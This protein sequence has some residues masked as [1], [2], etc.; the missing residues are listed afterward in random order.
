M[1]PL[2]YKKVSLTPL[3]VALSIKSKGF[4]MRP[5]LKGQGFQVS[6]HS[7]PKSPT[8]NEDAVL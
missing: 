1:N 4:S 5:T 7:F 2:E 3:G 6:N 8:S